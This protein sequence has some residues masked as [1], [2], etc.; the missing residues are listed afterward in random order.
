MRVYAHLLWRYKGLS[1]VAR[2]FTSRCP[3]GLVSVGLLLV[4]PNRRE[5]QTQTFDPLG[6][7][8]GFMNKRMAH[9]AGKTQLFVHRLRLC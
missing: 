8:L 9:S 3:L 6:N 5:S 1:S 4:V 7:V 2:S